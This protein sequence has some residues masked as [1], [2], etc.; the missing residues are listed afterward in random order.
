MSSDGCRKKVLLTAFRERVFQKFSTSEK[1]LFELTDFFMKRE[2]PR[3]KMLVSAGEIWS[4]VFYI[5]QGLIR[6][7]YI[8]K[9]GREFNKGFFWGDQLVW[10][11]APSARQKAS[12][13]SIAALEDTIVSVCPFISFYAWLTK[14]GYW[15]N[16]ALP[17]VEAFVEEKFSREY[18]FLLS[19]ATERYRNFCS[20]YPE[21]ENR[22]P[23]YHLASYIGISNVSLS[24]IKN[25]ADF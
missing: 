6:L 17:Y 10:P 11:I 24:R 3:N 13:F 9:E 1:E 23:D 22:I 21:L 15:E 12:K 7:F 16:F 2:Y 5:H 25:S 19:S 8:D 20:E 4:Q 14:H 18:E